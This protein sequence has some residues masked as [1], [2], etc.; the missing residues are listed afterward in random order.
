[1]NNNEP[2]QGAKNALVWLLLF[3]VAALV[4]IGLVTS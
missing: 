2:Q 3:T 1:M 4:L